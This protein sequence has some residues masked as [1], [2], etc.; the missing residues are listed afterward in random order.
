MARYNS[1]LAQ[2]N[3]DKD[4][5]NIMTQRLNECRNMQQQ[6]TFSS[7]PQTQTFTT[8]NVYSGSAGFASPGT[9][10]INNQGSTVAG[11]T[12]IGINT[13]TTGTIV[14][15]Y[16]PVLVS[17]NGSVYNQSTSYGYSSNQGGFGSQT[18]PYTTT[19]TVTTQ[20][21]N[22]QISLGEPTI[23][24]TQ[25]SSYIYSQSSNT[26]NLSTGNV[27]PIISGT[28]SLSGSGS[29]NTISGSSSSQSGL[30]SSLGSVSSP[31]QSSSSLFSSSASGS[32]SGA[33]SGISFP[34]ITVSIPTTAGNAF[35]TGSN[36]NNIQLPISIPA[37]SNIS[38]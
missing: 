30:S 25:G 22:V 9:Q 16:G 28:P 4:N 20:P 24:Q 5:V 3:R 15:Q 26:S 19:Q 35:V 37:N 13:T 11:Q 7:G 8:T 14:G 34:G 1:A 32:S 12:G 38:Y 23:S 33:S 10:T 36:V 18:V 6:Q 29:S 27:F 31:G 2:I 17:A 21:T